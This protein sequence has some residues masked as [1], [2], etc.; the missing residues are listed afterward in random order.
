MYNDKIFMKIIRFVT[1]KKLEDGDILSIKDMHDVMRISFGFIS[2]VLGII[3][4]S[5]WGM[6]NY[7]VDRSIVS[8]LFEYSCVAILIISLI[9][10]LRGESFYL[11]G[12]II[13]IIVYSAIFLYL[14][15]DGGED[16]TKGLWIVI[17]PLLN[18]FLCGSKF[19]LIISIFEYLI[20]LAL[21]LT[22]DIGWN[23]SPYQLL[24][25]SGVYWA[26]FALAFVF[27][28]VRSVYEEN[29][30]RL[31]VLIA[32]KNE[33]M[34]K[35]ENFE[36]WLGIYSWNGFS[37][38]SYITWKQAVRDSV[39]VS[40]LM[41]EVDAFEE[42]NKKY[43]YWACEDVL[44]QTVTIIHKNVRRPLDSIGRYRYNVCCALLYSA[45]IDS[46]TLIAEKI[47]Y[48][49]KNH[50]FKHA[51]FEVDISTTVSI[52]IASEAEPSA[53][54]NSLD[55]IISRADANLQKAKKENGN[56]CY[57]EGSKE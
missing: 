38:V 45:D 30:S 9:N 5:F 12:S 36:D 52:G 22:D 25:Y 33:L 28:L 4:T 42:L 39:S 18:I 13:P 14:F 10:L 26:I 55:E 21:G 51:G 11:N 50:K 37:T 15:Y 34:K 57:F 6:L 20:I 17:L 56:I 49:V 3:F 31:N 2:I 54:D 8:V 47:Y 41:I 1:A 27:E 29:I 24:K 48:E 32:N 43:G 35:S 46:A 23:Y 40:I 53:L 7:L 19:G 16:G 44:K